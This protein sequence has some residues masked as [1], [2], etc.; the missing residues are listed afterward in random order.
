ML[1]ISPTS[2]AKL[3]K[4]TVE[5]GACEYENQFDDQKYN[6]KQLKDSLELQHMAY[7]IKLDVHALASEPK[8]IP[9]A[10]VQQSYTAQYQQKKKYIQSLTPANLPNYQK[11]KSVVLRQLDDEYNM[12]LLLSQSYQNPKVLLT[13]AYG[14]KCYAIAQKINTSGQTLK[15]GSS[16]VLAEGMRE[17]LKLGNSQKWVNE[18]FADL[19][20]KMA[21]PNGELYAKFNLLHYWNNCVVNAWTD[22]EP[23]LNKINTNKDLFVKSK[24]LY[25]DS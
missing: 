22:D 25:C 1:C 16:E 23:F 6:V 2:F 21:K 15:I 18:Q 7:G 4:Y 9:S 8:D 5:D 3:Q 10:Q 12:N 20:S 19:E 17:Q 14:K 24:E 13:S 11:L